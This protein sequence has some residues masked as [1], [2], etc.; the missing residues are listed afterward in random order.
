MRKSTVRVLLFSASTM[1]IGAAQGPL[2]SAEASMSVA[3]M[4]SVVSGQ[5]RNPLTSGN[6]AGATV[7]IEE[8]GLETTTG[9]DGRFRFPNVPAGQY[10]LRASLLGGGGTSSTITVPETGEVSVRLEISADE[11][12]VTG[13]RGALASARGQERDADQFKSIVTADDIGQFADQNVAESLQRLPGVS[14]R[15]S[16][17]EGQQVAVRGLSGSFVTVT[18]DGARLGTRDVGSRSVNLDVLSSDLLQGIEVT[19]SLTPDLDADSIGGAVNLRSISAFDRGKNT[20]SLRAEGSYQE[21]S[22]DFNP[23]VSGDFTRLFDTGAGQFGLAGGVSWSRREALFDDFRVDNGLREVTIIDNPA[24]GNNDGVGSDDTATITLPGAIL[25]PNAIDQRADPAVRTRFSANLALEWRPSDNHELFTRLTYAKFKDDDIR[26]REAFNLDPAVGREIISLTP[27]SGR[28]AD[29][30]FEKRF[31]FTNQVDNLYGVSAGGESQFSDAWTL[32]YQFDYSLNDSDTPSFEAR[33]RERDVILDYSNLSI[34]GVDFSV[35]PNPAAGGADPNNPANF[36]LR[37]LTQYD[38]LVEDEITSFKADLRRDFSLGGRPAF[39][40]IGGKWQDRSKTVDV[41]RGRIGSA[42]PVNLGQFELQDGVPN[43]DLNFLFTPVLGPLEAFTFDLAANGVPQPNVGDEIVNVARDYTTVEKV[44]AG[45][46]MTQFHTTERVQM[47]VG[48]RVE[49]T[50]W[51]TAGSVSSQVNYDEDVTEALQDA[52]QAGID[53]AT[54]SFTQ[55]EL[56]AYLAP[57]LDINGDPLEEGVVNAVPRSARITYFDFYPHVHFRWEPTETIVGRA[58]FTQAIQRPN[59]NE[60]SAIGQLTF[61]EQTDDSAVPGVLNSLAAADALLLFENQ[62]GTDA[63][64]FRVP[65]LRPLR[66]NQLDGSLSFYPN[67]DIFLQIAVFYKAIKD[68]IVPVTFSGAEVAEAGL[69]P[70]DGTLNGGFDFATTFVNGDSADLY[71]V[72]LAYT[73]NYTFLP[74]LLSGL[75]FAGNVTFSDS[76]ARL[77]NADREFSLPDQAD[78]VGNLSLGWENSDFSLRWSGNYSSERLLQLNAGFLA[79]GLAR[80]DGDLFE[81][82]RW[83]MDVNARWNVTDGIQAYFDAVNINGAQDQRF[84]LAPAV[85]GIYNQ[86]EDYGATYQ[87]GVRARF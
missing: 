67:N 39:F 63:E 51:D 82:S 58:S 15:R 73:Q 44:Y 18:V 38:F 37:F 2:S 83:S 25:S 79:N 32:N 40:K 1:A 53:G 43:S 78:I 9:P 52:L 57:R 36:E 12:I 72:E 35:L 5:V 56:D 80:D 24:L 86:I 20:V 11:V 71:G 27:T 21:K 60:A 17:G 85:G 68:F 42:T 77:R 64:P 41:T 4:A 26:Q 76:N 47:M 74:G 31:R 59:F 48:F 3:A 8:L 46:A 70:G 50:V 62:A 13:T 22:E 7:E 54:A 45:Y 61:N 66:A 6:L 33:F 23:K 65:E 75:Y 84:F 34:D 14:I 55:A 49:S 10:T 28:I 29:V 87:I 69:T 16:E 30:D 81:R 19:K